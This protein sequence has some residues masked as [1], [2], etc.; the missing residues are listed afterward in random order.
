MRG[1]RIE[2]V[3]F[4]G[5]LRRLSE[6]DDHSGYPSCKVLF[7]RPWRHPPDHLRSSLYIARLQKLFGWPLG[8][9]APVETCIPLWWAGLIELVTGLLITVGL[10]TRIAAFIASGHMAFAYFWLHS[11]I[12]GRAWAAP[13]WPYEQPTAARPAVM[14]CFAFLLSPGSAPAPG[15]AGAA[16]GPAVRGGTARAAGRPRPLVTETVADAPRAAHRRPRRR[17]VFMPA[18]VAAN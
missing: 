4:L 15:S 3:K 1:R 6:H 11:P 14:F 16:A 18:S 13:F 12:T 7:S 8:E 9:P 2:A 10:F 17:P 5:R